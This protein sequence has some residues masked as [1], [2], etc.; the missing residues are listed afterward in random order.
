MFFFLFIQELSKSTIKLFLFY[1]NTNIIQLYYDMQKLI[2]DDPLIKYST[3]N[4]NSI[5][6][7]FQPFLIFI[8]NKPF[9]ILSKFYREDPYHLIY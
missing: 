2:T 7:I 6:N 8:I 4:P 9:H 1:P 5:G 3:I